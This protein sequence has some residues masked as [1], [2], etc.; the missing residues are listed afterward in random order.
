MAASFHGVKRAIFFDIF[1]RVFAILFLVVSTLMLPTRLVLGDELTSPAAPTGLSATPGDGSID[2]SWTA[3]IESDMA[4]YNIY[5]STTS[6]VLL[7]TPINGTLVTGTTYTDTGLTN[8]QTYYYAITA[9]DTTGNESVLSNEVSATPTDLTA[10]SKPTGLN[11]TAG[12]TKIDLSWTA[13]TEPD[14]AGY[15]IY[16]STTSPVL[17]TTPIN[18][19]LVTGTTYTNTG[20]TNGQ[21]YYYAITAKDTAGNESVLSNEASAT[22]VNAP[23]AAPT[24]LTATPGDSSIQLNWNANTEPDLAGYNIYRSTTSTV[25]LTTPIN[26]ALVTGTTYTDNGLTNG[27]IYYYV[28]TAVDNGASASSASNKVSATPTDLTAPSKPT[29]L[30]ATPGDTKIDLSWTANPVEEGVVGYNIYRST[31]SPVP[32]TSPINGLTLVTGT[33]YT[34][35]GLTNGQIYYYAITAKDGAGNES[36]KSNEVSATPLPTP[37]NP[38]TLVSPS[39]GATGIPLSTTLTVN[40]TNP[41]GGQLT[42]SFY[43]RPKTDSE[44]DF[45][46]IVIPDPQHYAE[47][48]PEIYNAQMDWVVTQKNSRNVKFVLSL[49]DNV[50]DYTITE[51]WDRAV[52]AWSI[53]SGAGISFGLG[54]GNKEGAPYQTSAFNSYFGST[55]LN[56]TTYGGRYGTNYDNT[57]HL[58]SVEGYNFII[59]FIEYD[60]SMTSSSHAVIQWA[61][62]VLKAY[63]NRRAIVVT[64]YLLNSDAENTFAPQGAAIYEGL[65]NNPNFFLMLGGHNDT[66]GM[67]TDVYNSNTVYSLRSDYQTVDDHQ[68]GYLRIM[69][70]SPSADKIYVSTYSPTQNKWRTTANEQFELNYAMNG[71]SDFKFLGSTTVSSGA[72]ASLSWKGLSNGTEYEWYAVAD[73]GEATTQSPTWSF[74]TVAAANV[75]PVVTW[76]GN[77]SN[78]EGNSVSLQITA[79]DIDSPTLT[80]SAGYLPEGLSINPTTGLISGTISSTAANS[81]PYASSVS[82]S[83]GSVSSTEYFTWTVTQTPSAACGSDTSLVACYQMDEGSGNVLLDGSM[84]GKDAGIYGTPV[85]VA[86]KTGQAIDFSGTGQYAIA[87]DSAPLDVTDAVTITGWIRPEKVANQIILKKT[88]GTTASGFGL[89]LGSNN[90]ISFQ[91]NGGTSTVQSLTNYAT[92]G[93]TWQHVAATFDG[94]N[95]KI[96]INGILDNTTAVASTAIT[97]NTTALG[98]GA[99]SDGTTLYQGALDDVRI[100]NRA[101]TMGEIQA[102][103]G[104][105]PVTLTVSKTGAGAGTVTSD[106]AGISCGSDCTEAY[107]VSQLVTLTATPD[108]GSLFSGWSG[109]CTGTG[110]CQVTMSAAKSVTAAFAVYRPTISGNT[111]VAGVTLSYTDG[112]AK[113]ATSDGSGNYSFTVPY[114]WS[115]VVIPTLTGYSFVPPSTNYTNVIADQTAQ[116]YAPTQFSYSLTV[117]KTGSGSGTVTSN[118]TGIDCGS[119]CTE[120]YGH[121]TVVTLTATPVNA[122]NRLKSWSGGGCSGN[123]TCVVTMD[124]A[125]TVTAEFEVATFADVPFS[126]PRWAYIEALYDA[127]LTAGCTSSAPINYCPAQVMYR[128]E[129]AVFMLRGTFGTSYTPPIASGKV[130]VDMTDT[131]YWSTKWAEGMY[132]AHM[133][134]GC[135]YPSTDPLKFCPWTEFTREQGAVFALNMKY[136][137]GYA[138]PAA[139]GT[140]FADMTNPSYWG[141]KWAEKAYADGLLPSCG[142]DAGSGKP[143]FCPTDQLD[144]S[145]SAYIIVQAKGLDLPD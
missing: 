108:P 34:N 90:K 111:G 54:L 107:P 48:Y 73:N 74:T 22:P 37:P 78:L 19:T 43:G 1:I 14:L 59:I 61:D 139:T 24:G 3:N 13:N 20:L 143:L 10:P 89:S 123:G 55:I 49:G 51:Q 95:L 133:T 85:W 145:W 137:T 41:E 77:Q 98:I 38:P 21:I 8:G 33:T 87:P 28:I 136:G 117:S 26:G 35:T 44:G 129:S 91:I 119:D 72:N 23:P 64:H 57:Y 101:M 92:D 63:S 84:Y 83:D 118:V 116:N 120:I 70:F 27:Q 46:L 103:I 140:V 30:N 142:T 94:T 7:T 58:F 131:G 47:A 88:I 135:Q 65:K 71:G 25:P 132:E 52:T 18:G 67:R 39:N 45:T 125:K 80:Y 122:Y 127:G 130:F 29:G 66:A 11:A 141:T 31:T 121:G 32:L 112:T 102:L 76:P 50:D 97:P 62:S 128:E 106:P 12:D 9:K 81:S 126:H 15:N 69:R 40:S 114:N 5:R 86:G 56:Q 36:V 104:V 82:V 99:Q 115:G 144:R 4:G 109:A 6:P 2:L 75:P 138:P 110:T 60:Y 124:A 93:T 17:L 68:S 96:Y 16:R 134:A 113:T 105:A 79:V 42:V 100:F 53:L